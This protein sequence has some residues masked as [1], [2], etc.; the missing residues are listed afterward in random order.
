[1]TPPF[2]VGFSDYFFMY[3]ANGMIDQ[4]M[5]AV[6]NA[7][8]KTIRIPVN[9][10]AV[11]P[12]YPGQGLWSGPG[13]N[14]GYLGTKAQQYGLKVFPHVVNCPTA[15]IPPTQRAQ[16][17]P[18]CVPAH[19]SNTPP[20][21]NGPYTFPAP[22]EYCYPYLSWNLSYPLGAACD[23]YADFYTRVIDLFDSCGVIEAVEVWNEPNLD[24][25]S[26]QAAVPVTAFNA[27]LGAVI[28]KV[29]STYGTRI[30]VVS[31]GLFLPWQQS[32][33][34]EWTDYVDGFVNQCYSYGMGL[35]PYYTAGPDNSISSNANADFLAD[36]VLALV[37]RVS[38]YLLET[39]GIAIQDFW[40]TET[41]APSRGAYGESGQARA[42]HK[43]C[44]GFAARPRIK[45]ML[46][47]R[48]YPWDE[49]D[50]ESGE[51][52][53]DYTDGPEGVGTG[54]YKF[55]MVDRVWAPKAA[56]SQ[57]ATVDWL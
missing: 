51:S 12:D 8:G 24:H 1:M 36:R 53:P 47:Y 2:K 29:R 54:F 6:V 11:E 25:H 50:H 5:Q 32:N 13:Y 27:M 20:D 35:H 46:V 21:P 57:L 41:G 14:Y 10:K 26:S 48:L 38:D 52:P 4:A 16:C 34:H 43:I 37:D 40:I 56:T 7:G 31:G 18:E 30:T 45:M 23:L 42:L 55:S 3:A 9:W 44:Q 19:A 33:I 28:N 39:H 15:W 49:D 22:Y 17:N